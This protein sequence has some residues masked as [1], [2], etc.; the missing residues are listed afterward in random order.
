[1]AVRRQHLIPMNGTWR[2]DQAGIDRGAA[3]R[4]FSFDDSTWPS[5]QALFGVEDTVPSPYALPFTTPLTAR[6]PITTYYRTKFNYTNTGGVVTLVATNFV[7]DGAV[8][9]LNGQ[10]AGRLRMAAGVTNFFAIAQNV[11]PE[12]QTNVLNLSAANLVNGENIMAVEVHQA[13]S[14]NTD[15]VF[16]LSLTSTAVVT[17][18]PV[19]VNTHQTAAGVELTLTGIAGRVYAVDAMG[20]FGGTWSNLI[21]FSNFTGQTTFEDT[22]GLPGSMRFYR[23][24]LVR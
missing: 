9:Y 2:Y 12:G 14:F 19:F 15:V 6:G 23:G 20:T 13:T 5:G 10:E 18:Q 22:N 17:N 8:F 24:R 21:T 1:V 7:D 4:H 3:W 16:G 11:T